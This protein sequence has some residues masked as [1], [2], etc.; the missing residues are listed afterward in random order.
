M[1]TDNVSKIVD[2]MVMVKLNCS[3]DTGYRHSS[4]AQELVAD[5][6]KC[7]A[8]MLKTGVSMYDKWMISD[9]TRALSNLRTYYTD[10]TLPW[11]SKSWRV[12]PSSKYKDFKDEL[13]TRI[14]E[15]QD[16]YQKVFVDEYDAL[17]D[18]YEDNKGDITLEFPSVE[19]FKDRLVIE[20]D[21]GAAASTSDIR[22]QGID[23]EARR[24]LKASME[25]Q[26]ES[27]IKDG[28]TDI[29]SR[30]STAVKDLSSRTEQD[31][32]NGKK[33]KRSL[34]N[35]TE[36]ADTVE[37]L[38]L[39]GDKRIKEACE[40]IRKEI[41]QWSPQAIKTTPMVR[42]GINEASGSVIEKLSTISI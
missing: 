24:E 28:V 1:I 21:M 14:T 7:S 31:D 8:S 12:I 20:Y 39:T 13:E 11:D 4:E 26:Y 23:Q 16:A 2:K 34:E 22:I 9:F 19:D 25:K 17:K 38:N 27:K 33:Y 36:L 3:Y 6:K 10:H 18:S 15:C 29:V 5:Q 35:L 32:Q 30:L 42:D 40:T 37:N 41:C